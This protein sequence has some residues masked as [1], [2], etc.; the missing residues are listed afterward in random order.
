MEQQATD[1]T[2]TLNVSG[3]AQ[4]CRQETDRFFRENSADNRYCFELFRRAILHKNEYAWELLTRQYNGLV[5][6]WVRRHEQLPLLNDDPEE[7][8]S[9]ALLQFWH[10]M[11]PE[12]F[13]QFTSLEALLSYLKMCSWSAVAMEARKKRVEQIELES[14][15]GAGSS[16]DLASDL[17]AGELW[18]AVEQVCKNDEER[19]VAESAFVFDMKAGEIS[20]THPDLFSSVKQVY[21]VKENLTARLR[22]NPTILALLQGSA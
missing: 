7:F 18:A 3:L 16:G 9:R 6:G 14:A 4:R 19:C 2:K 12:K 22:R 10:A 17:R 21:R 13:A 5:T 15:Y 1:S 8:V 11:T 20:Q